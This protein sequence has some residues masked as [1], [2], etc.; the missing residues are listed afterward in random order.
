MAAWNGPQ[1]DLT[2]RGGNRPLRQLIMLLDHNHYPHVPAYE[3]ALYYGTAQWRSSLPSVRQSASRS[4]NAVRLHQP[5]P[6]TV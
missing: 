3:Y 2:Y 4:S 1:L 6:V 5:C